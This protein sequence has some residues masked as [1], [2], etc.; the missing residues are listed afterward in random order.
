MRQALGKKYVERSQTMRRHGIQ[1]LVV[2]GICVL[3]FGV[4]AFADQ[5]KHHHRGEHHH[6]GN[7][8][9]APEIDLGSAAGAL[10]IVAG[11][12]T[13]LGERLRRP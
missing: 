2:L 3:C 5:G 10:T 4:T 11:T 7:L 6:H 9:P 1:V 8:V 13:L 12:L